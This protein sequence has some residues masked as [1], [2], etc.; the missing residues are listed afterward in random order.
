MKLREV[1]LVDD[2]DADLLY[3]GIIVEEAGVAHRVRPFGTA[4]EALDYLGGAHATEADLV[5]LDINMPEMDGFG[6]LEVYDGWFQQGRAVAAVVMLTS[7][8]DPQDRRRATS[9]GCVTH[10]MVKPLVPSTAQR[11]P[12]WRLQGPANA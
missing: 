5:L 2:S 3:T 6:F 7:S 8:D 4:I 9:F 1:V 10:Y 12:Q 11:L